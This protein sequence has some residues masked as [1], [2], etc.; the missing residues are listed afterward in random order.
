LPIVRPATLEDVPAIGAIERASF[1]D[2]WSEASFRGTFANEGALLRV[3]EHEGR[4]AGYCVAWTIG[5]EAELANL[6]V[7]PTLRRSGLGRILLDALLRELDASDVTT[8]Y[9]EVR[10]GNTAARTLYES[11][12]FAVSGRRKAYYRAPVEDA[13]LMRR[14]P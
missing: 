8:V 11:R 1:G 13:I 6:A 7:V 14:G 9:L 12:R 2:P 5:D 10:E 4:L 3:V